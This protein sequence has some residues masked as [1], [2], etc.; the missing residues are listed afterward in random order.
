MDGELMLEGQEI[1]QWNSGEEQEYL[2]KDQKK[3]IRLLQEQNQNKNKEK[4]QAIQQLKNV[5]S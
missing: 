2:I 4:D 5:R 3:Q 1:L